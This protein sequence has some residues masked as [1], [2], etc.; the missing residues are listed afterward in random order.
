MDAD[1]NNTI[2]AGR[3]N[4]LN[5]DHGDENSPRGEMAYD[6]MNSID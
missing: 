5:D 1:D 3:A 6:G 4:M 2:A